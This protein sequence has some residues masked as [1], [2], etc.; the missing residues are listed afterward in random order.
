[1]E[2]PELIPILERLV[3]KYREVP[4]DEWKRMFE[5]EEN[6]NDYSEDEEEPVLFWQSHTDILEIDVNDEGEYAQ[7]SVVIYPE[8]VHSLPPAPGAGFLTYKSG[9]CDVSTPQGEYIYDQTTKS[10]VKTT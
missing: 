2:Y 5:D 7:I 8:N 9:I 1:M 6:Y 4:F 3:N 10:K